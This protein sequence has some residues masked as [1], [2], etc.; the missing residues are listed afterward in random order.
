MRFL[1]SSLS[2]SGSRFLLGRVIGEE[3]PWGGGPKTLQPLAPPLTQY[4]S[5]WASTW[6]QAGQ[7]GWGGGCGA[8]RAPWVP[9]PG[10]AQ[11]SL[12]GGLGE[13]GRRQSRQ[14][15]SACMWGGGGYASPLG[16]SQTPWLPGH[17]REYRRSPAPRGKEPTLPKKLE[18]GAGP[19]SEGWGQEGPGAGWQDTRGGPSRRMGKVESP[20]EVGELRAGPSEAEPSWPWEK[21]SPNS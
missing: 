19:G 5:R 13:D 21:H 11:P 16:E 7:W 20:A 15:L 2:F 8:L 14:G 18:R 1:H 9:D 10:L 17:L 6:T 3:D 12:P 4:G